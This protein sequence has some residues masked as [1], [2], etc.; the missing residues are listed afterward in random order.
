MELTYSH[1]PQ[2]EYLIDGHPARTYGEWP[3]I[4]PNHWKGSLRVIYPNQTQKI[5]DRDSFIPL[6]GRRHFSERHST[7]ATFIPAKR[8][9]TKQK[10]ME[11]IEA[12]PQGLKRVNLTNTITKIQYDKKHFP[13]RF[14]VNNDPEVFHIKTFMPD[15]NYRTFKEIPIEKEFG[16]KKKIY[17]LEDKRNGMQIR[18][19]GDKFYKASEHTNGFF[20]EGGLIVGSTNRINYNKTQCKGANNFY[21]TLDFKAKM[22]DGSKLWKNKTKNE[23]LNYD[24]NYVKTLGD[25]EK[26]VLFEFDPP[27]EKDPK[28]KDVKGKGGKD[29]KAVG[30]KGKK[31]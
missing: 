18:I 12:K 20:K 8:L 28:G 30:G 1:I 16:Q 19:P 21:E 13:P 25:W 4:K 5:F 10:F 26:K 27:V 29:T 6:T 31:K 14:G 23:S 22:L 24:D 7:E 17:C 9:F 2:R 15:G 11:N 3:G